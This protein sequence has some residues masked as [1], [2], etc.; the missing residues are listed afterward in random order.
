MNL[1]EKEFTHELF[2]IVSAD[3]LRTGCPPGASMLLLSLHRGPRENSDGSNMLPPLRVPL[4]KPAI[5]RCKTKT[6]IYIC[7]R[8]YTYVINYYVEFCNII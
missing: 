3:E 4:R 6:Y 2:R 8:I 5:I 7:A 1:D